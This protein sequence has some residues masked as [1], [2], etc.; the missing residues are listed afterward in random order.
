MPIVF[1]VPDMTYRYITYEDPGRRGAVIDVIIDAKVHTPFSLESVFGDSNEDLIST[2]NVPSALGIDFSLGA[3]YPLFSYLDV[4]VNFTNIPLSRSKLNHYMEIA[5]N[6]GIDTRDLDLMSIIED[7]SPDGFFDQDDLEIEYKKGTYRVARPFKMAFYANYRPFETNP[8]F[9]VIPNL[10][11]SIN[12]VFIP[13]VAPVVSVKAS[14]DLANIFIPTIGIGYEDHMWKNSFGFIL[15]LRAIGFDFG[16]S[17]QSQQFLK[18]WQAAGLR[19]NF[20]LKFGW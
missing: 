19:A 17:M 2:M 3:E 10:G 6:V 12:P 18:S 15:N 11:F 5:G 20:G 8:S 16:I 1:A 9:T 14:Y 7:G 4:G 13:K